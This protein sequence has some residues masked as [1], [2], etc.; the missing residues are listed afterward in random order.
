[1]IPL[2][3][4]LVI[5]LV[6]QALTMCR[7][8]VSLRGEQASVIAVEGAAPARVEVQ[9]VSALVVGCHICTHT[10]KLLT[11]RP[12]MDTQ[13]YCKTSLFIQPNITYSLTLLSTIQALSL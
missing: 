13:S 3:V 5:Q 4:I 9:L 2:T 6:A 12:L 10:H 11:D 8:Q 1:M 7:D